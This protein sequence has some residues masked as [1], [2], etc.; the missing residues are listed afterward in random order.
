MNLPIKIYSKKKK[1]QLYYIVFKLYMF[2][3]KNHDSEFTYKSSVLFVMHVLFNF[4]LFGIVSNVS[5]NYYIVF[6]L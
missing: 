5:I 4:K 2:C 6:M 1:I 3:I